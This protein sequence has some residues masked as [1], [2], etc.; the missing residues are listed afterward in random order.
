M[1]NGKKVVMVM[2]AY[3]AASTLKK[4]IDE[5]PVDIVDEILLVDDCSRDDTVSQ[6]ESLGIKTVVH[7]CNMGYGGNQKTCYKTALDL[8]AD[9]VVMVHPDYQYTPLIISAMVSPIANGVFDC[10]LGSRI[11]GTGARKGGMPVYK[12]I[13]NRA[14]TFFQ[15]IMVGYHLS[16]YHTGYRAFSRE[17]LERIP[18]DGNS[19][20]FVFDNQMLCQIIYAGY[21]IGEV[22]CPTR[23]MD[24]SSSISFKRSVQYGLGVLKCSWETA[25]HRVGWIKSEF[26]KDVKKR[27]DS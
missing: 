15:N 6:A 24:D 1:V 26:L 3:N 27:T 14:L 13:A 5:L 11:L 10:M 7:T 21:D 17:L 22:T 4:T 20:D 23:Y 2:P 19:D 18:F 16:E 8:G 9:V 25:A 12:Y